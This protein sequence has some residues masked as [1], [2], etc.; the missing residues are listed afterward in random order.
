MVALATLIAG[1]AACEGF[2]AAPPAPLA[3]AGSTDG[4]PTTSADAADPGPGNTPEAGSSGADTGPPASR[5]EL[6]VKEVLLDDPIAYWRLDDQLGVTAATNSAKKTFVDGGKPRLDIVQSPELG[7]QGPLAPAGGAFEFNGAN[8]MRLEAI[9]LP[10]LGDKVFTVEVWFRPSKAADNKPRHIFWQSPHSDDTDHA[11]G[12]FLEAS[13]G[14]AVETY[15]GDVTKRVQTNEGG[16]PSVGEWHHLVFVS[17]RG[18]YVDGVSFAVG[19]APGGP[20]QPET[21]ET[22]FR[23][24]AK[25]GNLPSITGALAEVAVYD[26]VLDIQRVKIHYALGRAQE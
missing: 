17:P 15:D 6:Y 18:L 11:Y 22:P 10:Y 20:G 26:H 21:G 3:D 5:A 9:D 7:R 4:G 1:I 13:R 24:G 23:L 12:L 25:A 16:A 19:P 8:G 14:V 2:Q